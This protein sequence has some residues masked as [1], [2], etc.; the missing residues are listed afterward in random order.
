MAG[1][2]VRRLVR[3]DV[4]ACAAVLASLPDWFGIE[5]VNRGYVESLDRLPAFVAVDGDR[6]V[7]FLA[8]E[9]H[10]PGS[11][12]I[13]VMGVDP[14]HHRQGAGRALIEAALAWCRDEH[15]RWLHVKT[16]GPS[17][18]DE[19]YERTRRFYS[20]MGFDVLYESLTE[21]GPDDAALVMVRYLGGAT[22]DDTEG[23]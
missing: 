10:A 22:E 1:V 21:W 5:D 2:P 17:T 4:P 11:V 13:T 12:E 23:E 6:V 14:S 20:A 8:L 19:G 9:T 15:V 18:Y 3:S 16:R 7:G